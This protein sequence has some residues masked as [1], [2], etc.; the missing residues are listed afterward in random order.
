MTDLAYMPLVEVAKLLEERELSP[1][2]LTR[3][4][5][6][7]I[8]RIDPHL[9]S[10]RTVLADRALAQARRAEA[11]IAGG[12]YRGLLHGVPLAVKDLVYTAGIP[13]FCG[14][15]LM[16]GWLPAYDA[17]VMRRL[18]AAGAV[19]LGKLHMT[20]F[21]LRWHHPAWPVPVNPWGDN[22]WSGV[23]SSG[24][25][26][27]TAA[28]LCYGSLGTDT[29]GSIRFPAACSGV[30]GLKPTYGRVSR[31][32]VFPLAKSLDSV[33]PI[34]RRVADA[35][36]LLGVIAGHDPNDPTASHRSVPDYVALL[37]QDWELSGR[38]LRIG[39]DERFIRDGVHGEV[40]DAVLQAVMHLTELGLEA[41]E[42]VV[43]PIDPD[44][45]MAT[46]STLCAADAADA[47]RATWPARADEYGPFR[48][49]LEFANTQTAADY[50]A[51]HA[52]RLEYAGKMAGL[53]EEIDLLACPAMPYAAPPIGDEGLP[54]P[55]A[56]VVRPRFTYPFNFSNSPTLT[57]PCGFTSDDLPIALQLVGPHFS[58][59]TLLRVG[60][61]FEQS[62][63]WHTR[64]PPV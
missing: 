12:E 24:S 62:T 15:T 57:V 14:A 63:E 47:H 32:G 23:S 48:Q 34:T 64:V 21:A 35:A 38:S 13:T 7:R 11:E 16:A 49:W 3:Q 26:V 51:A 25:G 58:E 6:D 29:G 61:A 59:A 43:P 55:D 5:L 18:E 45:M 31:Y 9:H 1:V 19:L 36:A 54:L 20:E 27:A 52:T 56:T 46:W 44:L 37:G 53:F 50:A 33:G 60:H 8:D 30:V 40:S 42:V 41:V 10:Y 17:T 4:M 39:V 22:R 28:G 2:E